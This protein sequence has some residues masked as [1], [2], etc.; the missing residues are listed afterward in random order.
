MSG[1]ATVASV[2]GRD[3]AGYGARRCFG[4]LGTANFKVSHA[5]VENGV[6]LIAARH[7]CNAASMGDAYAKATGELTLVSVHSGPGLTNALT[8][9]AEAAKSR[10]PLV[11]LAG[12]VPTG[13]V[14]NNFY[15]EQAEMVRSVGAVCERLHTPTSARE[16]AQRAVVRA[17]RDRQTVVLSMPLDVQNAALAT[18]LPPLELPPAPGRLHPDP[19][20]IKM[21]AEALGRA[22][23][24]LILGGRGAVISD[25]E[26]ALLELAARVGALVATSVCGHGLFAGNPWS[27]GISGGFSSPV[28]DELISESDFI[29]GFGA[30]FTQWTTKRGKLIAP[31]AVVAQ[32]DIEAPKL[33]YQM[34]VQLA[35]HGDA[36]STAEA[37]LVELDRQSSKFSKSG[38]RSDTM[39]ERIR[40]GDNHHF[41]HPD[42]SNTQFIDPRTLSKAVDALLPENRVVASD[43]GH[44]C[45]WVPRYLRVPNARASCL[46]HSFQSVGLGLPSVIGL[47]VAHPGKLA[48]LGAGDGGFMMSISDFE[49]AIRLGLRLC[50]LVYN[51]NSYAAE[52]HYF[53]RQ[54]FSTDIV[55]FPETDFAAIARGY[56]ARAATVRTIA[57]LEPVKAWVAEGAPGVFVIDGKI[58]PKLEADWHSEHFP[59]DMH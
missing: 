19:H 17:L 25:A 6:E 46:S 33:G 23:R 8:G 2:I 11:V 1:N 32:V 55:R 16:D 30:S 28:A 48:V 15:I 3:L 27:L 13:A 54:G 56:G 34:P 20:A 18:N 22:Q 21:L 36:R 39:R 38:R 52:V 58:N 50:I 35:V 31:G 24:P 42:E 14:K 59:K 53:G 41:P 12:D 49:T 43:S 4:L 29:L 45:G 5:L 7:E 47:A 44:F 10:T 57:D 37:L 9:I 51:D 40:A 26:P